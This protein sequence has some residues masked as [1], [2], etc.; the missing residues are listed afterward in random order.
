[1]DFGLSEPQE[2]L[3]DS[4]ASA[5]TQ[6]ADVERV[7]ELMTG[8]NGW[9][10]RLLSG[11]AD[12]GIL[13]LLV[14]EAQGGSGLSLLD[15]VIAAQEVGRHVTP[16]HFYSAYVLA[17]LL[18]AACDI[19]GTGTVLSE[20]AAGSSVCTPVIDAGRIEGDKLSGAALYVPD[21]ASAGR[22][23]VTAAAEDGHRQ[24]H[25]L[26]RDTNGVDVTPL[27][28]VD[29]TR[30]VG[31]VTFDE[32]VVGDE[33]RLRCD[34]LE[35]ALERALQAARIAI[36][37][38]TLGASQ[39]AIDIAVDYALQ[40]QQFGRIIGSFQAVKHMCAE[41]AAEVDPVQSLL[42]YSAFAWDEGEE[43]VHWLAPL[44]KSHACEVGTETVT[45]TT[46]VFGGIGFTWECDMHLY[47]KRV[48]LNRQLLG[49]PE[50]LRQL[51]AERQF[52]A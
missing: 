14:P 40:R 22:F 24:A 15:A 30:R 13:G 43:E 1:M 33:T 3:R 28:T 41:V 29:Q 45:K 39:R 49:G 16:V 4:I 46:Q 21:A 26:S 2:L 19:E 27:V 12:Q 38:D 52:D 37:A 31:E 10:E 18:L 8:D 25:L 51:A 48:G 9:D 20:I 7:R 11:L 42:W 17:P 34:D 35:A 44:L 36:A 47:F 50:Q 5:L 6:L 32:C 23:L